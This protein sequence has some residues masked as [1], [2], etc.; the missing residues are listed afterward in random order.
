MNFPIQTFRQAALWSTVINGFSQGLALVFSMAMAALFGAQE[1]TDILYYWLGLSLLLVGMIQ[2]VNVSVLIPE[3]MRRRI[4]TDE[5]DAMAFINRFLAL[6]AGF[7]LLVSAG[8]LIDPVGA[9][10]L[11]S[12]FP[13]E[14]LARH[15]ALLFWLALS[16][17]LQL[18]SQLLLDILISYRFLTLPAALSCV[19]RVINLGFAWGFHRRFGVLAVAMGMALG[20]ALQLA[21]NL[22]LLRRAVGWKFGAWSMQPGKRIWRNIFWAELGVAASTAANYLALFLSTGFGAGVITALS[23]ARRMSSMPVEL[24]TT[25][26]SAVTA[27]K[28]NELAARQA[29]GELGQ[30][31]DR[32]SRLLIALLTPLAFALALTGSEIIRLFYGR[33]AFRES[34]GL[35]SGLFSVFVLT[36][37]LHAMAMVLARLFVARQRVRM[38]ASWQ[39]FSSLLNMAILYGFIRWLGPF[40]LAWGG[41]AHLLLYLLILSPFVARDMPETV[42]RPTWAAFARTA[43][44]G[45][46]SAGLAWAGSAWLFPAASPWLTG[47][48]KAFIFALL[49]GMVIWVSPPDRESRREC[50]QWLREATG[51]WRKSGRVPAAASRGPASAEMR[52]PRG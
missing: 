12:K 7:I 10:A 9:I 26:V 17:P 25:Q 23:Y 36:L 4:Q 8:L 21:L 35:T 48:S 20:F 50:G 34:V 27:V 32:I 11:L 24:L 6:L 52:Q 2:T 13:E 33:G 28:F 19:S 38:G 39:I 43:A 5:R 15:A 51:R 1:S 41:L 44:A 42:L 30:S 14:T 49:Y 29:N 16:F 18:L 3:T 40:G 31:G 45:G 46:L 47:G 37:P 22:V